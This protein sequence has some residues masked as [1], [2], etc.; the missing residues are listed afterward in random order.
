VGG[1]TWWARARLVGGIGII[2]LLVWRLG[3]EPFVE[4]LRLTNVWALTAAGAI[5][6]L[7]TVCCA[8]RWGVVSARLGVEVPLGPA[9]AAYYRSQFLNATLPGGVLGDVHRAVRHGRDVGDLGGSAR[10]VAA[11]RGAG[12]LVQ[13]AASLAVLAALPSPFRSPVV[14]AAAAVVAVLGIAAGQVATQRRLGRTFVGLA[15]LSAV[16]AAGHVVIFLIAARTAGVTV[17]LGVLLPVALVV[18]LAS[19]IP[20]NVAGWGPREGVAAWAFA[21]IGLPASQGVTVAVVYGVMALVATLPGAV[22][23]LL[24]RRAQAPRAGATS[25]PERHILV[26]GPAALSWEGAAGG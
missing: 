12:Q 20:M 17:A 10:S 1:G 4:G 9:V 15:G 22:L 2:G 13:V 18:M 21:A 19:A 24:G 16:A 7:A 26:E 8:R 14:V 6:A 11:E 3:A 23:I 25:S 5:T